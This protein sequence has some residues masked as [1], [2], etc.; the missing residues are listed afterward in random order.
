MPRDLP[1]LAWPQ[2]QG[3]ICVRMVHPPVKETDRRKESVTCKTSIQR[4]PSFRMN[5][6][7][8]RLNH[9]G[10]TH[11]PLVFQ[12]YTPTPQCQVPE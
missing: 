2:V 7:F 12:R 4:W 6:R 10:E 1:G 5:S 3:E 11:G 8:P 9:V